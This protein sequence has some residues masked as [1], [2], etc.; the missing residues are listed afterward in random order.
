M[1]RGISTKI[2]RLPGTGFVV[3]DTETTGLHDPAL[4]D[5]LAKLP[6]SDSTTSACTCHNHQRILAAIAPNFEYNLRVQCGNTIRT[7]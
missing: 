2:P 7:K 4:A 6:S 1:N 5:E 3:I